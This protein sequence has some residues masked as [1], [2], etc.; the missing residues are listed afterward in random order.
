MDGT[1]EKLATAATWM[2]DVVSPQLEWFQAEMVPML[3]QVLPQ[4]GDVWH[5]MDVPTWEVY[6]PALKEC[7]RDMVVASQS[8]WKLLVLTL[9][10][11]CILIGIILQFLWMVLQILAQHLLAQGWVS[12]QKGLMQGK[13]AVIW[14]YLFQRSLTWQEVL[15]EVTIGITLVAL[16]YF[17]K[18]LQRQTYYDR[19]QRWYRK[20]RRQFV[21]VSAAEEKT[22][23]NCAALF[24]R[25]SSSFWSRLQCKDLSAAFLRLYRVVD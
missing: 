23:G 12:L 17:R 20:K 16:Y 8:T 4:L 3:G 19:M 7:S 24:V 6:S 13:A 2:K 22:T 11:L 5:R 10:P 9:R 1:T 21:R 14:L 25:L 18:W 15:G